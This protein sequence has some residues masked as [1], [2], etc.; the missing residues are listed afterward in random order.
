MNLA[1]EYELVYPALLRPISLKVK[2]LGGSSV[3]YRSGKVVNLLTQIFG[4]KF[5]KRVQLFYR[6]IADR[7]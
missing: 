3:K 1:Y 6:N 7:N 5:A 4:W 2:A